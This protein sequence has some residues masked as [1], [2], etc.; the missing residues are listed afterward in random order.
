LEKNKFIKKF[1]RSLSMDH[2][3]SG[4]E[5]RAWQFEQ[6]DGPKMPFFNLKSFIQ[7]YGD[8]QRNVRVNMNFSPLIGLTMRTRNGVTINVRHNRTIS[9]EE[10]ANGGQKLFQDQAYSATANYNKRGGFNIPLPFFDDLKIQNQVNFTF[11]FDMN[12]NRTYQKSLEAVKF[13]ETA[14]TSNWKT[15]LRITYNF[16]TKI[17][18]SII[19]EYR[20]SDSKHTGRRIDRDFGFDINLAIQG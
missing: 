16:S 10:S 9:R 12:K 3:L 7:D 19:W 20:E 1:L 2:A 4:K 6:F 15:G 8:Q 14:F 13:A 11:N 18:G 5:S 17:S